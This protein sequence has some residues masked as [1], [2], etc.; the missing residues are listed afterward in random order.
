M[1]TVA[2]NCGMPLA[3][4]TWPES[5]PRVEAGCLLDWA[6]REG[7]PKLTPTAAPSSTPKHRRA[8]RFTQLPPRCDVRRSLLIH[9]TLHGEL[10]GAGNS[11]V[12]QQVGRVDL[13]SIL[14]QAQRGQRQKPLDGHLVAGLLHVGG[15]LFE[16]HY[17]LVALLNGIDEARIAF[18]GFFVALQVVNLEIDAELVGG[19]KVRLQ[20]RPHLGRAQHKLAGAD[21]LGGNVLDLVG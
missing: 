2:P 6:S 15:S 18:V 7:A 10:C 11:Y 19:G 9:R 3:S 4:R 21:L 20:A 13:Q 1:A 16:L 17:L 8:P 12:R 14:P 5:F